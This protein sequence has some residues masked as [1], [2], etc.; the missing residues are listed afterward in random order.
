MSGE[1]V[2]PG[3]S[4]EVRA[5]FVFSCRYLLLIPSFIAAFTGSARGQTLP[6]PW[7]ARD[8]GSPTLSGSAS[9]DSGVFTVEAAG[10]DI[11]G[12]ADQFHF[13]YQAVSGDV[14]VRARIDGLTSTHR[15][16]KA[17]VMIRGGLAAGAAHGLALVSA[18]MGLAFQHRPEAGGESWHTPGALVAAPVW[19][20]LVREGSRVTAYASHDGGAWIQLGAETIA[21]GGTAYVGIAVTSHDPSV[22]TTA[23]VSNVAVTPLGLPNGQASIDIGS[24]AIAGSAMYLNGTYRINAGGA[25]IWNSADQFHYVYQQLND[26]GEVLARVGSIGYTHPW[27][28]AGVMIRETLAADSRHAFALVSAGQGYAFQRRVD[29]GTTSIH[30]SGGGGS[31]PGWVRLVRAGQMVTAYRSADGVKWTVIG[32]DAITMTGT[33]YVG[34]AVTSHNDSAATTAVVDAL[35]VRGSGVPANQPPLVSLTAP[36]SGT[37]Y[38]APAAITISASASDPEGRMSAVEFYSGTTLLGRDTTS[39]YATSWNSVPAGSYVLT[40][41]WPPPT[42]VSRRLQRTGTSPWIERRFSAAWRPVRTSRPCPRLDRVGRARARRSPSPG[43]RGARR[44]RSR[45]YRLMSIARK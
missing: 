29:P 39:P 11:W 40:A 41:G 38:T 13:V 26:D 34:I 10:V 7:S 6:V 3:R 28:K 20:R 19:V 4:I 35:T 2:H 31:A 36:A 42:W 14:D 22:R 44:A 15:W 45:S 23:R 25:D 16:A 33:V 21:L 5:S 43:D 17:G 37:G 12:S 18:E 24:P 9:H 30:T 1:G 32:S 27:A 8:I